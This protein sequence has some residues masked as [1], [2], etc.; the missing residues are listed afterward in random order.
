MYQENT[1]KVILRYLAN[2]LIFKDKTL[3]V[4]ATRLEGESFA[5]VSIDTPQTDEL[6][7]DLLIN[8]I[9]YKVTPILDSE[10][11]PSTNRI[12]NS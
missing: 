11:D 8:S 3:K 12:R 2:P 10:L 7:V 6:A 4:K 9:G 1:K 5:Q